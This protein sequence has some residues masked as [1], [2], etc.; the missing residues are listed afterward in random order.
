MHAWLL[1]LKSNGEGRSWRYLNIYLHIFQGK[2]M[3]IKAGGYGVAYEGTELPSIWLLGL[4][5]ETHSVGSLLSQHHWLLLPH[6]WL[7]SLSITSTGPSSSSFSRNMSS[8]PWDPSF[9]C[10]LLNI[11]CVFTTTLL[12]STTTADS[13][14]PS[15]VY[16]SHPRSS[17]LYSQG[18]A[19][20][21]DLGSPWI[22]SH[23]NRAK[24][25]GLSFE[26]P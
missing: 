7:P 17:D 8:H 12:A 10:L 3:K 11:S 9:A 21:F 16:T 13:K 26:V 1:W 6:H 14:T 22:N 24:Q 5:V 2:C 4:S 23:P 18:P 19:G 20:C 25:A 15:L